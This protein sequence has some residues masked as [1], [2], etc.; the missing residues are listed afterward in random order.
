MKN[1]SL[2]ITYHF[3]CTIDNMFDIFQSDNDDEE[4]SIPW[5]SRFLSSLF[6]SAL[7]LMVLLATTYIA[8]VSLQ[9]LFTG[10]SIDFHNSTFTEYLSTMIENYGDLYLWTAAVLILA[11]LAVYYM[12]FADSD[13]GI[14][15]GGGGD[16]SGGFYNPWNYLALKDETGKPI[17]LGAVGLTNLGN[18]CYMS[19][20]LQCLNSVPL[21]R[22]VLL[23]EDWEDNIN[24]D[25]ALGSGGVVVRHFRDLLLRMWSDNFTVAAP[26][27]FKKMV[28]G[29]HEEFGGKE[30][31]DAVEFMLWLLDQLH[32][33]LNDARHGT[34]VPM[35]IR[36]TSF[37]SLNSKQRAARSDA[38]YFSR[39]RS[40]IIDLFSGQ[41]SSSLKW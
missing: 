20:T 3:I 15:S 18:S 28:G 5:F 7:F 27:K 32:E 11:S 17:E 8:L 39:N 13:F 6:S 36:G 29:L 21:L 31:Q 16:G 23:T 9:I 19:A 33:D 24:E 41:Q 12:F 40:P 37:D 4:E 22:D 2:N 14:G 35:R 38:E 34:P 25:N 1:T 30:Q 26:V 10:K